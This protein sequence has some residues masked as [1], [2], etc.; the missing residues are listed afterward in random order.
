MRQLPPSPVSRW[1]L[2]AAAAK[3]TARSINWNS[4][5]K[6]LREIQQYTSRDPR[7][8]QSDNQERYRY[9]S[10]FS[11]LALERKSTEES[12]PPFS[13]N[14]EFCFRNSGAAQKFATLPA[15]E[16]QSHPFELSSFRES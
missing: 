13:A 11:K 7:Y 8:S 16:I 6:G 12:A 1:R 5:G 9:R 10:E 14:I 2:I 4:R 3:Q 15:S